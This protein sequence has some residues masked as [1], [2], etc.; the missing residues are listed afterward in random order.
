[1][2]I[3]LVQ[4]KVQEEEGA[5]LISLTPNPNPNHLLNLDFVLHP[6]P[7]PSLTSG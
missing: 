1:M 5:L 6:I 4:E 3:R 2:K 7:A